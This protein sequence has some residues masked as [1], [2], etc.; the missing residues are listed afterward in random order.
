MG[1]PA[2]ATVR[3][4]AKTTTGVSS[5]ATQWTTRA[6]TANAGSITTA[7]ALLTTSAR[8]VWRDQGE[9]AAASVDQSSQIS[10]TAVRDPLLY[11]FLT[12][13]NLNLNCSE[14]PAIGASP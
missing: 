1:F 3:Q 4:S 13:I 9:S 12:L 5:S 2:V 6:T 8:T 11:E 10:T 7:T 14:G